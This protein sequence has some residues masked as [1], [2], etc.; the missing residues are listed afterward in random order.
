M[1]SSPTEYAT[2]PV[3]YT[4]QQVAAV[5]HVHP[6]YVRDLH[7][8]GELGFVKSGKRHLTRPEQLEKYI[9]AHTSD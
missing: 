2:T 5:L 7:R 4:V 6:Q 9:A 8:S 1:T 3:L